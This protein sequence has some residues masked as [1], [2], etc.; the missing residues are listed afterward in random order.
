ML[1]REVIRIIAYYY[2][3]MLGGLEVD[4]TYLT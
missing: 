4:L 2:V 1:F 3:V